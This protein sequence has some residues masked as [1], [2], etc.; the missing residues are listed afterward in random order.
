MCLRPG[1]RGRLLLAFA[2]TFSVVLQLPLAAGCST[3]KKVRQMFGGMLPM[4]VSVAPD[5]NEDSPV[6]VDLVVVYN[7]K[8][9]DTLLK[10][11]S[12]EW[13]TKRDQFIKDH[14][15]D[16]GLQSW[17]WVPGQP[18]DPVT[19]NYRAGARKVV[20]F[21]DYRTDGEHRAAVEPQQPFRLVL[22]PQDLAVEVPQ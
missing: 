21:A 13:F 18:V 2:C 22:G 16:I 1:R 12:T 14:S 6:A 9:V 5:V 10:M 4:Q 8:L 15:K 11:P 7:E 3:R 17:E 19:I 20:L